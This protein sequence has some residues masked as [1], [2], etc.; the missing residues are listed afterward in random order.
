MESLFFLIYDDEA[1]QEVRSKC[2]TLEIPL[3]FAG[4]NDIRIPES[5]ISPD[6]FHEQRYDENLKAEQ[7]VDPNA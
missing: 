6:D 7:G 2:A 3:D 5:T 4:V 1:L